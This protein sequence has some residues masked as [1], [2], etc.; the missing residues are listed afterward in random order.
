VICTRAG[1]AEGGAGAAGAGAAGAAGAG[2]AGAAAAALVCS[3]APPSSDTGSG[4]IVP[5]AAAGGLTGSAGAEDTGGAEAR[6]SSA[7]AI[8]EGP[9]AAATS[10]TFALCAFNAPAQRRTHYQDS[11]HGLPLLIRLALEHSGHAALSACTAA[12]APFD[13]IAGLTVRINE[14]FVP[15]PATPSENSRSKAA[16]WH[17]SVGTQVCRPCTQATRRSFK[18]S[19]VHKLAKVPRSESNCPTVIS[20]RGLASD[21]SN[22]PAVATPCR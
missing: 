15:L 16:S 17:V 4:A 6:A 11:A 5:G 3:D 19:S 13:S 22:D 14:R 20:T 21:G 18:C 7:T 1:A 8:V 12:T 2:A 10:L 9:A